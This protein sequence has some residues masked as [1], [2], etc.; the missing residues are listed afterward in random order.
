MQAGSHQPYEDELAAY[1]LGSGDEE[2][3]GLL[4]ASWLAACSSSQTAQPGQG[5]DGSAPPSG[6]A[7]SAADFCHRYWTALASYIGRCAGGSPAEIERLFDTPLLC[8]R[9]VASVQAGRTKFDATRTTAC[10]AQAPSAMTSCDDPPSTVNVSNWVCIWYC[11]PRS[12][13]RAF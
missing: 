9:F 5:G 12:A 2:E 7:A 3:T 4:W 10:L 8:A 11:P 6:A 13:P 1:L